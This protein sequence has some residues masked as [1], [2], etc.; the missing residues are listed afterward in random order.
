MSSANAMVV[1]R[2]PVP[3]IPIQGRTLLI[4]LCKNGGSILK[5]EAPNL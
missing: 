5:F 2:V 1:D 4:I 3:V